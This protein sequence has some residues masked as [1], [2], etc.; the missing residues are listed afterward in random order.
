M[1][2]KL[3]FDATDADTIQDSANVGAFLRSADGTLLTHTDVGG[4]KALD[5]RVAEGINVEVDLD[6][7][8]D[9]V[10]A[11]LSDGAGN[12]ISSTGG[13]LHISD[14]G[15][16]ITVDATN[17]D[18]RDLAFATD[19][20]DVSGSEVSLDAAT[21][22]ALENITVSATDLDIRDLAFATDKVDVTGSEVSLDSATLAALENITVSATDL[23]IRDLNSATDSVTVIQGTSPWVVS[24]TDLDIR[25]LS[26]L[27]DSVSANLFDGVG[28]A[29]S[30]TAG[31]LDVNIASGTV[32]T[33]DAALANTAIKALAESV[34]TSAAQILDGA[35]ELAA[36]KYVMLY[37]NGNRTV[38]IGE[39]GVTVTSGFPVFP[40]SILE[41]RVGAAVDL[42]MISQSG[43]QDIRTLQLS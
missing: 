35:D 7:A 12:A 4:K 23:D 18:I 36:R 13:A 37:N 25:D 1:I 16:S 6:A 33:S 28:N 9:S 11:W 21:L 19:K 27:Q 15:G 17:L 29:I 2:H 26:A 8:D 38:F 3:V 32:T 5:V 22:A 10:A 24:A 39:T 43:T 34:G 41:A 20:V 40:G 31:A 30:S 42:F 14:A